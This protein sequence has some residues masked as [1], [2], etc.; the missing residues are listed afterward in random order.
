MYGRTLIG[1]DAADALVNG[2][3][4]RRSNTT[5]YQEEQY[6]ARTKEH[7]AFWVLELHGNDIA[8]R[9]V[10]GTW[11]EDGEVRGCGWGYSVVT[12]DRLNSLPGVS[13]YSTFDTLFLN[14]FPW[15]DEYTWTPREGSP[16]EALPHNEKV[17]RDH[18]IATVLRLAIRRSYSLRMRGGEPCQMWRIQ[19]P[20]FQ[21]TAE[22]FFRPW[23]AKP[24]GSILVPALPVG[25]RSFRFKTWAE[26]GLALYKAEMKTAP[27]LYI[28]AEAAAEILGEK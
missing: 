15:R 16:A 22:V 17:D 4:F 7:Q 27:D 1:Q 21:V 23:A 14:G 3:K 19:M 20:Q 26:F 10:S 18:C 11:A 24:C 9:P 28:L 25:K 2:R 5:V 8:R 6:D 12:K 13:V